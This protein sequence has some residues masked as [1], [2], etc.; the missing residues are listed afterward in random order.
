MDKG[1]PA[2][3]CSL[4]ECLTF[5]IDEQ[6]SLDAL[7][8]FTATWPNTSQVDGVYRCIVHHCRDGCRGIATLTGIASQEVVD[9]MSDKPKRVKMN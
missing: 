7:A 6:I 2:Y 9:A 3:Y 5:R 8:M 4:C 1:F